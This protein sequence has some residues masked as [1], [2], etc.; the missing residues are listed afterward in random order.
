MPPNVQALQKLQEMIRRTTSGIPKIQ[1]D[2]IE[3]GDF[4][5]LR[6]A[7]GVVKQLSGLADRLTADDQEAPPVPSVTAAPK[8]ETPTPGLDSIAP[9]RIRPANPAEGSEAPPPPEEPY[10]PIIQTERPKSSGSLR[11]FINIEIPNALEDIGKL[12][13]E[14][15][16][17]NLHTLLPGAGNAPVALAPPTDLGERPGRFDITAPAPVKPPPEVMPTG[18]DKIQSEATRD[19]EPPAVM[20]TGEGGSI[21]DL[22]PEELRKPKFDTATGQPL[23][24]ETPEQETARRQEWADLS[25]KRFEAAFPELITKAKTIGDS[26][27][28]VLDSVLLTAQQEP[29][30]DVEKE[31]LSRV[32]MLGL[33]R[34]VPTWERFLTALAYG[35]ANIFSRWV[36]RNWRMPLNFSDLYSQDRRDDET[37]RQIA[38]QLLSERAQE[39]RLASNISAMQARQQETHASRERIANIQ[40]AAK[41]NRKTAQNDLKEASQYYDLLSKMDRV[42]AEPFE[43]EIDAIVS[44]IKAEDEWLRTRGVGTGIP[45]EYKYNQEDIEAHQAKVDPLNNKLTELKNRLADTIQAI[46]KKNPR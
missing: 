40:A 1:N 6:R 8:P 25:Q 45:G 29:G 9:E 36:S 20:P 39:K 4:T 35:A 3:T 12:T 21:Y 5:E 34:K 7:Q 33:D 44:Q 17:L 19:Q 31:F 30:N 16:K 46:R 18:I 42:A 27:A 43:R 2:A 28:G 10:K 41:A 32:K 14:I 24:Q 15:S 37:R 26:P 13:G 23:S 22:I 11:D 38:I